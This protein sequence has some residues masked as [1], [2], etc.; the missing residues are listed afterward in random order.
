MIYG[1]QPGLTLSST[2]VPF[3]GPAGS[4]ACICTK[5][6]QVGALLGTQRTDLPIICDAAALTGETAAHT[7]TSFDSERY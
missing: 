6:S 7:L 4:P 5:I 2:A 1:I 3:P